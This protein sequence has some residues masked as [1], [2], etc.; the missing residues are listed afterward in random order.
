MRIYEISTWV[1]LNELGRK[2]GR[3]ITLADVPSTE[4]D[5][6]AALGF[7]TVWLMG[8]WE[9][10][11]AGIVIAREK[12]GLEPEFHRVLPDYTPADVTGSPYCIHSYTVDR[13]LGGPEGLAA[14]R[15]ALAHRNLRLIL[16]FVPNHTAPDHPWLL[17]HPEYYVRGTAADAGDAFFE[18]GGNVFARGRDPYFAPW[19]DTAQLNAFSPDL[20]RAF[21]DTLGNIA[22]MS[23]G[24]RCDMAMLMLNDVFARTWG[25]RAGAPPSAELW[26]DVITA[27]KRAHPG[28][29]FIAEA[30]WDLEWQLQQ[31]GFDYC[32]DKRLYDRLAHD[33]AESVRLHLL[34]DIGYQEKLVRF[35]EN[36]D[37]PRAAATFPHAKHRAA[38]V[39]VWT[40]PGAKLIYE[41]QLEGRRVKLPVQLG[42]RPDEPVDG[43]LLGFYRRLLK[44]DLAGEWRLCERSGW[45]D[46]ASFRN[47]VAWC[48]RNGGRRALIAVNLSDAPAQ[49]RI[50]LPWD[51][52]AGASWKLADE[53]SE[54]V[55]TPRD[56]NEMRDPGL[57]V[58]LPAWGYGVFNVTANPA[59]AV[60]TAPY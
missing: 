7:D 29:T 16:D 18:Y 13:N 46:N 14:A 25:A 50:R 28:F 33:D 32:Y 2:H 30:Y 22:E 44:I 38:A 3:P 8:V 10:S 53:L 60:R 55:F 54:A 34:A 1:W 4:W 56:G 15:A 5:R 49:A 6:I 36:H 47:V 59:G 31:H 11:P 20:R 58:D 9:R 23:D 39:T 12:Q 27:V 43:E 48:W 51:D 21:T 45:P 52:L 42:R 26:Q 57:Y 24:V 35:L 19:P 37:E 17:R 40:L 41:G